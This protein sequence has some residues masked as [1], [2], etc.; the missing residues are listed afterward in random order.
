VWSIG[1]GILPKI[2]EIYEIVELIKNNA[3]IDLVAKNF[4]VVYG[5]S[6][7]SKNFAEIIKIPGLNGVLVG[8]AS[9]DW[10]EMSSILNQK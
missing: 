6:V 10:S 2:E 3:K 8:S 5:G 9:N 4:Q 1:S 7:N